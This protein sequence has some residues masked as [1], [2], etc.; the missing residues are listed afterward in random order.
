VQ[1]ADGSR[2]AERLTQAERGTTNRPTLWSSNGAGLLFGVANGNKI[3]L[4]TLSL[5]DKRSA[6][7]GGVESSGFPIN[8]A[9]SPDG[10]W[11]A[12][13]VG[14]ESS[15]RRQLFVQPFPATG[16]RYQITTG[17]GTRPIWRP[18]GRELF[19]QTGATQISAVGVKTEPSFTVGPALPVPYGEPTTGGSPTGPR[20]RDITPEGN[21]F[22][23][24]ID[25]DSSQ[26]GAANARQL[27]V[28]LN[29]FEELKSLVPT[30]AP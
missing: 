3:A 4:W 8:A 30:K 29:W 9:F 21:R 27:D 26:P 20:N 25:V 22:I 1:P 5:S 6:P 16:A 10:K 24:I 7:F 15:N 14:N 12:Y 11:V 23:H 19:F 18:D 28:V 13:T 17:L 2:P